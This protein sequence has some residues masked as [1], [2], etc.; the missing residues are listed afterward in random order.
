[1]LGRPRSHSCM[2]SLVGDRGQMLQ[3][4]NYCWCYT[5]VHKSGEQWLCV[6]EQNHELFTDI[7]GKGGARNVCSTRG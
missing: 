4:L 2:L 6:S 1:M 7:I 3:V 5:P